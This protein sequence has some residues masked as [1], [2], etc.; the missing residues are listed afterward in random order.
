MMIVLMLRRQ[1]EVAHNLVLLQL[2][3]DIQNKLQFFLYENGRLNSAN[4][5]SYVLANVLN[6][7]SHSGLF[8]QR[9]V[10]VEWS[11]L[12]IKTRGLILVKVCT[13]YHSV[14][15]LL[16]SSLISKN[17]KIKIYRTIILPVV[18]YGC[19]TWSFSS[20]GLRDVG[21]GCLRI[22]CWGN[23]SS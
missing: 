18:C 23:I 20:H 15:K 11:R 4:G 3:H 10:L 8:Q 21:W 19:E 22:V 14:Q 2:V 6:L 5:K 13:C 12:T 7:A 9:N 17:L 1:V 16:S